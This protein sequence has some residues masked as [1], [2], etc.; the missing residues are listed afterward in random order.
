MGQSLSCIHVLHLYTKFQKL[1][2]IGNLDQAND[3]NNDDN[4]CYIIVPAILDCIESAT[5]FS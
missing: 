3:K 4:F 2:I 5:H 1:G